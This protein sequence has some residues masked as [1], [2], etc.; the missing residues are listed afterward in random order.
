MDSFVCGT[1]KGTFHRLEE[2]TK[3]KQSHGCQNVL[4]RAVCQQDTQTV[5]GA[6]TSICEGR[7]PIFSPSS[8]Y[9]NISTISTA[10][11]VS[12]S[13]FSIAPSCDT[14]S[15]VPFSNTRVNSPASVLFNMYL[16][17]SS[18]IGASAIN[19]V[20]PNSSIPEVLGRTKQVPD[21]S[22]SN[23]SYSSA[24][25]SGSH[26]SSTHTIAPLE[27]YHQDG[28]SSTKLTESNCTR[29]VSI[30]DIDSLQSF[31]SLVSVAQISKKNPKEHSFGND[32]VQQNMA[33]NDMKDV[34]FIEISETI[35]KNCKSNTKVNVPYVE[36]PA[37]SVT[38]SAKGADILLDP[39]H[40]I[41]RE[42][43]PR[44]YSN[45]RE[46]TSLIC[47]LNGQDFTE[48]QDCL[49][50]Y[51]ANSSMTTTSNLSVIIDGITAQ[52]M[53][54]SIPVNYIQSGIEDNARNGK[55]MGN[56]DSN[57]IRV[58]NSEGR[59]SSTNS[60]NSVD[61]L[62]CEN[63]DQYTNI[64]NIANNTVNITSNL[65]A[66]KTKL[67]QGSKVLKAVSSS[68][69]SNFERRS[70]SIST[71]NNF[72][73]STNG[74][75]LV[76]D[77]T[78][79]ISN[80]DGILTN[81]SNTITTSSTDVRDT[82]TIRSKNKN[83][84]NIFESLDSINGNSSG[85]GTVMAAGAND[86]TF[87]VGSNKTV[88]AANTVADVMFD[89][90]TAM[91]IVPRIMTQ[92]DHQAALYSNGGDIDSGNGTTAAA[93]AAA[94]INMTKVSNGV[95]SANRID[96]NPDSWC[97]TGGHTSTAV[98]ISGESIS[99]HVEGTT[100]ETDIHKIQQPVSESTILNEGIDFVSN[101]EVGSGSNDGSDLTY[102]SAPGLY[103]LLLNADNTFTLVAGGYQ[104]SSGIQGSQVF[105]CRQCKKFAQSQV[106]ILNHIST[107]HPG[108]LDNVNQSV[109]EFTSLS[110]CN[111]SADVLNDADQ[112]FRPRLTLSVE[113]TSQGSGNCLEVEGCN[114][115]QMNPEGGCEALVVH[116]RPNKRKLGRPR[117]KDML[118]TQEHNIEATKE[119]R[120]KIEG[121]GIVCLDCRKTFLKQRQF[122]KHRC[123]MWQTS[124]EQLSH[125]SVERFAVPPPSQGKMK[126]PILGD[127]Y[128]D[129][130][131]DLHQGNVVE[132]DME[133]EW[134]GYKYYTT[135]IKSKP[136]EGGKRKRGRP[137]KVDALLCGAKSNEDCFEQ[138]Q[139]ERNQATDA[140]DNPTTGDTKFIQV[141]K[142]I[143]SA[144]ANSPALSSNAGTDQT[145]LPNAGGPP[146]LHSIPTLPLF[147]NPRQQER[148]HKWIAQI[149]LSFVDSIIDRIC[150]DRVPPDKRGMVMYACRECKV[151]FR[152][153]LS[154]RRHC[155]KHMSKKA[156]SCPDCDFATTH[157][158]ALYS[159]YRNHTQNLYACDKCDFRARIK[160][161]YRDH[162]ETHNPSRHICK[163]CQR[164]YSTSNSLKSHIYLAHR[165]EEGMKYMFCL[166]RKNQEQNKQGLVYQCPI[167]GKIFGKRLLASKHIA[168]HGF[169][170]SNP[171]VQYK[172]CD[173]EPLRYRTLKKHLQKHKVLYI[174]CVCAEPQFTA[175]CLRKHLKEGVCNVSPDNAY[176]QSLLCSY[177]FPETFSRLIANKRLGIGSLLQYLRKHWSDYKFPDTKVHS[178]LI[179]QMQDSG[180]KQIYDL[181]QDQC[182]IESNGNG[183]PNPLDKVMKIVIDTGCSPKN[184]EPG[185]KGQHQPS[186]QNHAQQDTYCHQPERELKSK[187]SCHVAQC[188]DPKL[189]ENHQELAMEES[190]QRVVVISN[191]GE[192]HTVVVEEG[193]MVL[194]DEER[195][196]IIHENIEGKQQE[197]NQV[198]G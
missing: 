6:E 92:A 23:S 126:E 38:R 26:T 168:N 34:I 196:V 175:S 82:V 145:V 29:K 52:P 98:G 146:L 171:P 53:E 100:S 120:F 135:K 50:E 88:C 156:F 20:D 144:N 157:V 138:S 72:D 37:H 160:A 97:N 11:V 163:L 165:N 170:D 63:S 110:S 44:L 48:T 105:V 125:T 60:T 7:L 131:F 95:V 18:Q 45:E 148:L 94:T 24:Y 33:D 185:A 101:T 177:T 15:S 176:K 28:N 151:L 136:S 158:G 80:N 153:L 121:N 197:A 13:S 107:C 64:E 91:E 47:E 93:A 111:E 99:T 108:N 16:A 1:C 12:V 183:N 74:C 81:T 69:E 122:D 147:S 25:T 84:A 90:E 9:D 42:T 40:K 193:Q 61:N 103:T 57:Y 51:Y 155:A 104:G 123:C 164:P 39:E 154:C 27:M 79:V 3:H 102:A 180:Y 22:T 66:E 137:P 109:W 41:A 184:E 8:Q 118:S 73:K 75:V 159:H 129:R 187:R 35:E 71:Q 67:S 128:D 87:I 59:L 192:E 116:K 140:N 143:P 115:S 49:P 58:C 10:S 189:K 62:L 19:V 83:I 130:N 133:E 65:N 4:R 174:C 178:G 2:F 124:L 134:K 76:D 85:V 139:Q 119:N 112:L 86:G 14:S 55:L 89:G 190:D 142:L 198:S 77:E 169:N 152:T 150:P 186:H 117:K 113:T 54:T 21:T 56:V 188:L 30:P 43:T 114:G 191:V 46:V 179:R 172:V 36:L 96:Q 181:L 132:E 161:H 70:L 194:M 17:N 127:S 167:C 173:M 149:D 68:S 78:R 141:P 166:R 195:F 5:L 162:L 31:D 106:E 32:K 182:H